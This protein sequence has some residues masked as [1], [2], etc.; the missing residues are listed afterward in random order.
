MKPTR[1]QEIYDAL[2]QYE[3]QL[4]PNPAA[5]GPRYLFEQTSKCRG[6]LNAVSHILLEIHR[7][8]HAKTENLGRLQAVYDIAR[9]DLLASDPIIKQAP[10]IEDRRAMV[11]VSLREQGSAITA[12]K[13]ELQGLDFLY[14]AVAHRHKELRDTMSEIKLHRSLIR[15][16]IDTKSFYGD[17]TA[18]GRSQIGGT[19]SPVMGIEEDE[20]E[21]LFVE[22]GYQEDNTSKV[23]AKIKPKA[24]TASVLAEPIEGLVVDSVESD[25]S[26]EDISELQAI[27]TFLDTPVAK[28][29]EVLDDNTLNEIF[30]NM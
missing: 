23:E 21:Q 17:E 9:E 1:I 29:A 13:E 27:N 5:L 12:L 26:V 8:K 24:D 22:G 4:D 15:D 20:L 28:K 18:T 6:H 10:S 7:E 16:D 25:L 11:A 3:L 30:A 19:S 14:K 2:V